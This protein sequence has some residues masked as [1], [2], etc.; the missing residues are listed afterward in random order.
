[1]FYV[2]YG[3]ISADN[4]D[5]SEGACYKIKEFNNSDEVLA[6]KKEFDEDYIRDECC[7]IE[8]RVFEGKEKEL[9]PKQV[10]TAY[11]LE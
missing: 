11:T 9:K 2:Y 10:V 6:F 1:M 5:A 7:N 8:F 3:Y 4:Y